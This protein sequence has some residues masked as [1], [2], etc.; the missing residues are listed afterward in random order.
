LIIFF[1]VLVEN[2]LK[3]RDPQS[4]N[5]IFQRH[6]ENGVL[7]RENLPIALS[8]LHLVFSES[9]LNEMFEMH[10]LDKSEGL[11]EQEFGKLV[12][13]SILVSQWI[14]DMPLHE[15]LADCLALWGKDKD[16]NSFEQLSML[17]GEDIKAICTA[18]QK[19][20]AQIL[21]RAVTDLWHVRK[22]A[23]ESH[24]SRSAV[25]AKFQ[26]Y[27]YNCGSVSDFHKG[28]GNR[29]G[30]PCFRFILWFSRYYLLQKV[31]LR[32]SHSRQPSS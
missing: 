23:S 10:D 32:V 28:L 31:I 3:R 16:G 4:L 12:K 18:Y 22:S 15:L 20:L 8:N 11:D 9:K 17:T 14:R 19:G 30:R 5:I 2:G 24:A 27:P 1:Q 7:S 6:A 29:L 26:V 13:N 21:D 25:G